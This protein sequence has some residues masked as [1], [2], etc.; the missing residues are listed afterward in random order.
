LKVEDK[1]GNVKIVRST[2]LKVDSTPPQ[3]SQFKVAGKILSRT[4]IRWRSRKIRIS[5]IVKDAGGSGLKEIQI[6]RKSSPWRNIKTIPISGSFSQGSWEDTVSD[7]S[8]LYGIHV[9]D[10]AG[11]YVT[12]WVTGGPIQ[13]VVQ[14]NQPPGVSN[15]KVEK[16]DYCSSPSHF[17]SWIYNDPDGDS[18]SKFQFQVDDNSDFSS[19]EVDR[20]F[21]GLSFSSGTENSQVV[22]VSP[23]FV[24]DK[25]LYNKTYWWRVK[26]WDAKGQESGWVQGPA[27]TTEKHPYPDPDFSWSPATPSLDEIVQFMGTATVYGGA[28]ISTWSW[29][30][31]DGEPSVSSQQNPEVLFSSTGEKEVTLKVVDSDG[32]SCSVK[33]QLQVGLQLP[34]WRE[35]SP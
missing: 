16:G 26:V 23:S 6:K 14:T 25:L 3:L 27:F 33:K 10:N 22:F 1:A 30:F 5:W 21:D 13:V 12:E 32:Y 20:V 19:P 8:Y 35:I 24:V 34:K 29:A 15:L 9:Y 17:F 28:S 4:P 7:G 31:E 2:R 11:N 18:E